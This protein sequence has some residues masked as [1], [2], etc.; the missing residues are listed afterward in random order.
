MS[1][2]VVISV[3]LGIV[4]LGMAF[5]GGLVSLRPPRSQTTL[6]I[7]IV[8]FAALPLLGLLLIAWQAYRADQAQSKMAHQ[9]EELLRFVRGDRPPGDAAALAK[10]A[11]ALESRA[12]PGAQDL[13]TRALLLSAEIL[14]FL[15]ERQ[16]QEP[17]MPRPETWNNDVDAMIRFHRETM[18]LYSQRFASRVIAFRDAFAQ[19]G[20]VDREL[21]SFYEHPTNPIGI[22]IVGERIG[23]LAEKL[24]SSPR[25]D[26]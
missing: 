17:P 23:A 15:A 16:Q 26:H 22:R 13:K 24:P 19:G 3:L 12:T 9:V 10:E 18:S 14:R 25:S 2:N 11:E 20:L 6:E 1:L 8:L 5:L 21:D 7:Y 4:M